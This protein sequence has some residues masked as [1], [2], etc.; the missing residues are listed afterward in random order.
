[1]LIAV[2][3]FY[4][5]LSNFLKLA[6]HMVKNSA[7]FKQKYFLGNPL[8]QLNIVL[9]LNK[10]CTRHVLQLQIISKVSF[11]KMIVNII[12]FFYLAFGPLI[13]PDQTSLENFVAKHV[14]YRLEDPENLS[15][16]SLNIRQNV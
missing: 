7:C 4:C 2:H 6:L 9:F 15:C 1:M 5:T 11:Y 14:L 8:H 16:I 13:A 12:F 10:C 3:F